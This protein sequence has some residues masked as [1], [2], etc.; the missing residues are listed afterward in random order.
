MRQNVNHVTINGYVYDLSKLELRVSGPNSKNPGTEFIM[1][2]IQVAVDEEGLN[3]IPVHFNY[4]T[5][6]YAKSGK[7]NNTFVA[8]KQMLDEPKTWLKDGKDGAYKISISAS[9]DL[10]DFVSRDGDM[11]AAP[12]VVGSFLDIVQTFGNDDSRNKFT[13]DMVITRVTHVDADPDKNIPQDF[14]RIGGCIF[15]YRNSILP[16]EFTVRDNSGMEYFEGLDASGSNPVY[17]KVWGHIFNNTIKIERTEESAFGQAAVTT[18]ERKSRDW[19]VDGATKVPYEF[20]EDG[21]LTVEELTKAMQD[22]EVYLAT[23]KKDHET[24]MAN[25][26]VPKTAANPAPTAVPA[27]PTIKAGTFNF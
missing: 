9:L 26:N 25:R 15:N 21:V 24:Y 20:G 16:I 18:Y 13:V 2:D 14:T 7:V 4:T 6:V 27:A 22:R 8:M 19:C 5:G 12:R 23:V 3:V 11:V 1:G 10:N 17:T